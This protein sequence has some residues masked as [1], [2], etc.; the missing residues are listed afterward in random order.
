MNVSPASSVSAGSQVSTGPDVV[1][2][3][4]FSALPDVADTADVSSLPNDSAKP[5]VSVPP[6]V[7]TRAGVSAASSVADPSNRFV[8]PEGAGWRACLRLGFA[9]N[10]SR[11]VLRERTHEGPLYVQRP[12][13]PEGGVSHVYILHPPA[14]MVGGDRLATTID[15]AGDAS[16]LITTPASAKIYRSAGPVATIHQR[17]TVEAG[18]TLEWLPQDTI[19]FGGSSAAIHTEIHLAQSARF[20]GW[21]VLSLGRPRSGDHYGTGDLRSRTRIRVDGAPRLIERQIWNARDTVLDA[22]WGLRGN[23][24]VAAFYIYPA[25]PALL[26]SARGLIAA[27]GH[28]DLAVTLLDDL[29]VMRALGNDAT[30]MRERLAALWAPLR[31]DT[32]G[33]PG[34]APR[35]WAT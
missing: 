15:V 6:A 20:M 22:P 13:Y 27:V 33:R 9:H 12:F 18:G 8:E 25:R 34:C 4:D 11:T 28:D 35:I 2:A 24:V 16:A 1:A 30:A 29:L 10:G 32:L 5:N 31:E 3:P 19:L 14:G 17:L 23:S 7:A 21:E 26:E